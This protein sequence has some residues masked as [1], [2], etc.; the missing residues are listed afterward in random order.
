MAPA[1]EAPGT[2]CPPVSQPY[3]SILF[4]I[5]RLWPWLRIIELTYCLISPDVIFLWSLKQACNLI[6]YGFQV[7]TV[8]AVNIFHCYKGNSL[9]KKK[10]SFFPIQTFSYQMPLTLGAIVTATD[11]FEVSYTSM[12][13]DPHTCDS[14][15]E[16]CQLNLETSTC[17]PVTLL[18]LC[19]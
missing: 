15:P 11:L 4:C 12:E 6:I 1:W 9:G 17:L 19:L 10:K 2:L 7:R 16:N 18:P 14:I 8:G 3:F 13:L 5:A